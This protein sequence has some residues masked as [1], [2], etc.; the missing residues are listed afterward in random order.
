MSL[1]VKYITIQKNEITKKYA[2]SN[3]N[4]PGGGK[5]GGILV[6]VDVVHL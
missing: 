6:I 4:I 2:V 3:T 1:V 5:N